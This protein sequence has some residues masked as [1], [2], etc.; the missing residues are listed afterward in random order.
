MRMR[1][2]FP[3]LLTVSSFFGMSWSAEFEFAKFHLKTPFT[4]SVDID[5]PLP[6]FPRPQ[7][8]R[9]DWLNLNGLWEYRLDKSGFTPVQGLVK[10]AS[11][12]TRAIPTEFQG[13]ILV[14]FAIDAPLSGV[15]HILRPEELLWYRRSFEVPQQWDGQ[16]IVLRLQACDW[17]TSV[18]VNGRKVGQHRGGYDPFAFDITDF[19]KSGQN[20]LHVCV[21]DGTEQQCQALGKQIMPENRKGFRYQSTGGIW[22][23]V[24][25]EP[26]PEHAIERL[27]IVPDYDGA[28]VYVTAVSPS[29]GRVSVKLGAL[30]P[31]TGRTNGPIKVH[32]KDFIAWSPENPHLYEIAVQLTENGRVF[33]A[34]KSYT[35]IRKIEVKQA[36]HGFTRIFLNNQ[37]IF[38][39]GPLDQGYWPDGVL[40]P[41]TE[42]AIKFDLQ[43]LKDVHCN[44]IRVHIKTHP[45]RWYYWADK[46]GLLVWQDM[47]CMPKYGQK[48]DKVA[49]QQWH[50]EFEAMVHWLQNHPSVVNWIVFNE[51][52]SQHE[53][54]F[55][56]KWIKEYDPTRVIT[57]ASGWTDKPVGDIMDT[58]HYSFYP[59]ANVT[60]YKLNGKRA[61]VLGEGGGF[62]QAIPGH[63]YYSETFPPKDP[64]HNNFTPVNTFDLK[65]SGRRQTYA[66]KANMEKAHR[67][68]AETLRFL[69]AAGGCK[70]LVYTQITDV[71]HE[72]NGFLTYDRKVSKVDIPTLAAIHDRL[73]DPPQLRSVLDY[74]STWRSKGRSH[75]MPIGTG[76]NR[77]IKLAT[78]KALPYDLSTQFELSRI[79]AKLA[80]SVK[81]SL[82]GEIY[83]NGQLFRETR[84]ASRSGE[85]VVTLYPMLDEEMTLLKKGSNTIRIKVAAGKKSRGKVLDVAVFVEEN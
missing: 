15:G 67:Q 18:Y 58:H 17:E 40:T 1:N 37:A 44:M 74:G 69:S 45:D 43:Y 7:M 64:K 65:S 55:F 61:V 4:D 20:E 25:L 81:G 3:V 14:P 24:W 85:P 49:S 52:W 42:E 33:D 16:R 13:R 59:S 38:Q 27:K 56:T 57:A 41:P 54:E 47:I 9:K 80:V 29:K 34:V 77:Y 30:K 8:V 19:L 21:W 50:R 48:V 79:P 5:N 51:G 22:Q 63:T 83:V 46:L 36:A 78:N 66:G 72:L 71:E 39:Y 68:F 75:A 28:C 6:E 32:V 12:T 2:V 10:Q 35:G 73:F 23:T 70:A 60:D 82:T 11:L 26:L 31:V 76:P 53:T 62:N 84:F